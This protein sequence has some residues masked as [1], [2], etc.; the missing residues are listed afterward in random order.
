VLEKRGRLT[1]GDVDAAT[2]RAGRKYWQRLGLAFHVA[3]WFTAACWLLI[4]GHSGSP[5]PD[6]W[7]ELLFWSR[8]AQ[9]SGVIA[10]VGSI[11]CG[12]LALRREATVSVAAI[13]SLALL[14]L[15]A[16]LLLDSLRDGT[17]N[18]F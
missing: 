13:I 6:N 5:L 7:R 4:A 2:P 12:V 16:K 8:T 14:I 18:N 1:G 10:L 3:F 17:Y 9:F 15:V 11:V